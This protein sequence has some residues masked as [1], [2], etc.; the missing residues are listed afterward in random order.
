MFFSLTEINIP[1]TSFP[2]GYQTWKN[3]ENE[4]QEFIFLKTNKALKYYFFS[5]L[6]F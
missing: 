4:F 5:F 6:P 2:F 1:L 3:E